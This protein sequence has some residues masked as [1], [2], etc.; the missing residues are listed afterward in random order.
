MR[1]H[2]PRV[3]H[4]ES[5]RVHRGLTAVITAARRLSHRAVVRNDSM[6]EATARDFR[7]R[8][9]NRLLARCRATL[10]EI[11]CPRCKRVNTLSQSTA[12]APNERQRA[13]AFGVPDGADPQQY[14]FS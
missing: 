2:R 4:D 13:S 11:K 10:L 5:M 6:K 1:E 9:C 3:L 12:S 8:G 14:P 7:C